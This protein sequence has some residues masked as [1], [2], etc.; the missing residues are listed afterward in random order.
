MNKQNIIGIVLIFAVVIGFSLW[1]SPSKNE[2][3]KMQRSQD[4]LLNVQRQSDSLAAIQKKVIEQQAKISD[5]ATKKVEATDTAQLKERLGAFSNAAKGE[6]KFYTLENDLL[7]IKI[8]TKGG[9]IQSVQLKKYQTYD[10]LPLQ[11]FESDSSVFAFTFF[12]ENRS[13]NT[14]QLY[15][16]PYWYNKT[17]SGNSLMSVKGSDSLKFAMR[18]YANAGDTAFNRSQ[19][20]EFVYTLK[21]DKYDVGYTVNFVNLKDVI[22]NN[23]N[24]VSLDW[25]VNMRSQERSLKNERV[26]SSVYYKYFQDE[27]KYLSETKDEEDN[28]KT[29]VK[30]ISFKD[31]FFSATLIAGNYFNEAT[32]KTFTAPDRSHYLKTMSASINIPLNLTSNQSIPFSFYFGPNKY[33]TLRKYHLDL[34]RQIP[35][36]W[37]FFLM[38]WINRYTVIPVFDFLSKFALN[39]GIIILIL[40]LLL[41][42]VLFPIAYK[43]YTS[44]AKMRVLK[45][46]VDEIGNKFPKK[47]DA[48]KKQQAVMALYKKAGVN[49]MSGCVP[50]L[51]QMPI[52]I[53][54]FRFFP[55]SIELRQQ[56]FL[57][58]H[59]LSSYDSILNLP[60][61]I[62]FYGDH[63][64]LFCLLMT[65][66]TIIYT[67]INND[68]MAGS[69]QQMPGM[70]TMMYLM[71]V[72]FLGFFND[73]SSGLSYYYLLANLITFA[74]MW[75]FR[76]FVN[77][78]AIR[79]KIQENKKKTVKVSSFQKRLEDMAKQRG[80]NPKR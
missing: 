77:E 61:T 67:K 41:K 36:G 14:D 74:Q 63:V 71:P 10:S 54:L 29:K 60:F 20:L 12:A 38:Q 28:L 50:L 22:A 40:T 79:A 16:Q 7:K 80:Y 53:A 17:T 6:N 55:S 18:I 48:M 31:Q 5:T 35:L 19:Y 23:A 46:D 44:S 9:R 15:F 62:P 37:S 49:P 70:K 69:T 75:A 78:D 13:I 25:K 8:S 45:P 43:T 34:E 65:I 26:N 58:A 3:E 27:V 72:M 24:Y 56:S 33:N 66:S 57:W 68:M 4:S 1:Q 21:G 30:W 2:R 64:S 73:Y 76:K 51:L 47:E 59:D 42:I 32:I 52:L 39:Y 11:I